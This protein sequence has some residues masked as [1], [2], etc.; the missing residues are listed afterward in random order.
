MVNPGTPEND[1]WR[2]YGVIGKLG[3]ATRNLIFVRTSMNG[4][5]FELAQSGI[6]HFGGNLL[7]QIPVLITEKRLYAF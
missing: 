2:N 1:Y 5:T 6:Y 7:F 3:F 4:E